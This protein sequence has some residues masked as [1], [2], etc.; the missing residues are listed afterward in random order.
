MGGGR[1]QSTMDD[2]I[3]RRKRFSRVSQVVFSAASAGYKERG[4]T[5]GS[6]VLENA[7][8]RGLG[9]AHRPRKYRAMQTLCR[10][11]EISKMDGLVYCFFYTLYYSYKLNT[12]SKKK[13]PFK[14]QQMWWCQVVNSAVYLTELYL[15]VF[16]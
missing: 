4:E 10:K 3:W 14:T 6:M 5:R 16:W 1:V 2:L 9:P 11:R 8:S 13:K 15:F 12:E 7:Y